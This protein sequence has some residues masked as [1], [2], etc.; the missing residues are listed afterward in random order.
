MREA[1]KTGK[2][3]LIPTRKSIASS[4]RWS[5]SKPS[6]IL[7]FQRKLTLIQAFRSKENHMKIASIIARY[8]LGL[9][10]LVFGLNHYLNFIPTGPM[11]TGV[12][13]Q[14]FG[15]LMASRYIYV[16]AFFEV[17]PAFLLLINRYVP[18]ALTV[19]GPVIVNIVLT[20][21]LMSPQVFPMAVLLL[22]LWPL[23]A[24]PHRS[25]FFPLLQQRAAN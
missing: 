10:F 14:F 23:A 7:C 6:V 11:P 24:W 1:L 18:L 8:L 22:I 12:A 9:I 21:V 20:I 3:L 13:G 17:V 15:S 19:L 4:S 25:L 2:T 5:P 16:V